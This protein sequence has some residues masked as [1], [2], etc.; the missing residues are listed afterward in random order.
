M[1]ERPLPLLDSYNRPRARLAHEGHAL[2][3]AAA[4]RA[5]RTIAIDRIY[6][7]FKLRGA[8]CWDGGNAGYGR[9]DGGTI[10]AVM[11]ARWPLNLTRGSI[12]GKSIGHGL[13][14]VL[15]Y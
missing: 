4:L 7:G 5:Q 10:H 14:M 11:A 8:S 13:P 15:D 12:V 6:F 3:H 9:G 1:A 2:S